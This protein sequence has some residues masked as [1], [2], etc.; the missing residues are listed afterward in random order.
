MII[1]DDPK[2]LNTFQDIALN[3]YLSLRRKKEII[4]RELV[5]LRDSGYSKEAIEDVLDDSFDISNME[6]RE[7]RTPDAQ[8]LNMCYDTLE[9]V[10][11]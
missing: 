5:D 10:Y 3:D 2:F 11:S 8:Y 6:L 1:K 7:N 4:T 9:E